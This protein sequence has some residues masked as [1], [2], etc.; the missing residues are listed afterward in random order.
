VRFNYQA[1]TKT[2][3]IQSGV[4][5]ASGRE[6]A[7]EV[8]KTHG[9]YATALEE[10]ALPIYARRLK[11]FERVTR[12][13]IVI[14]SRQLAIMFKSRVPLVET[15]R[16]LAEQT[17]N[18]NFREKI[19]KSAEEIE[20][21]TP[22][23]KALALHPKLFSTFYI[24]MVKSGEASGKLVDVFL[25]LADYLEREHHFRGKLRG[26]MLYPLFILVVFI[27]VLSIIVTFVIPQLG[28]F[29]LESGQELPLLTRMVIK[30]SDF[31]RSRGWIL[32]LILFAIV[33]LI[34]RIVK[35][36]KGKEFFDENL[37]KVPLLGPFLKKLYLAR[38]A[39]NLSTLISGGLPIAQSL[40]I[41][42]EVVGNETYK[43]IILETRDEIRKG[44]KMSSVLKKYPKTVSPLFCQ[45]VVVGE[46]TGALESSLKNVVDFYQKDVDRSLDDF[47]KLLEPL[48]IIFLGLIVGG[49][50]AAVLIPIYSFSF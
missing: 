44:E 27:T 29:L 10:A 15:F 11:I 20:G 17:K 34:Y 19:L 28:E 4:V 30:A 43:K 31:A 12:K 35:T 40:Q 22:L 24:S 41:T 13:D 6:A 21:G 7:L 38:F 46:K 37:L 9:L 33:V 2:G 48:L 50:M 3:E 23:S 42:G 18:S 14:F 16:T 47:I 39:L 5:E 25:Y 32:L 26:A 45:M 1:R 49:L 36:K 8:L